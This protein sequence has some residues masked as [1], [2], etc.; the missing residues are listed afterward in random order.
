[1][2]APN[3]EFDEHGGLTEFDFKYL[4]GDTEFFPGWGAAF[5]VVGEYCQNMGYGEFGHPTERGRRV[6]DRYSAKLLP[7][8]G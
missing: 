6:M 4:K 8:V 2:S 1:M 3:L 5:A 7:H